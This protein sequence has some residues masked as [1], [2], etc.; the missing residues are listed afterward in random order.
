MGKRQ[1]RPKYRPYSVGKFRLNWYVDQF[2]ASWDDNGKRR[3]CR[4][5]VRTEDAARTALHLFAEQQQRLIAPE[6]ETIRRLAVAYIEDRREEGK[7]ADRMEGCWKVLA[8]TF[9]ALR[10]RDVT[11]DICRGYIA[12]RRAANRADGTI[13]RELSVLRTMFTWAARNAMIDAAPFVWMPPRPAPRDRHLTRDEVAKL[14]D[15][16]EMPHLRLFVVLAIVTA[17]RMQAILGLTW[18]R[19]DFKRGLIDLHDPEQRK[20]AKGRAIVPMNETARAALLEAQAGA[21]SPFVIEWAGKRV[22]SIKKGMRSALMRAGVR[23]KGD[24]AH[25]LRHTAAV[26][27]AEDGVSMS[28]IAQYLGH[29]NT[30][31]TEK[32]YARFSPDY[33]RKAAGSLNLPA[34]RK[35]VR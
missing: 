27:M 29:S 23:M 24:G 21:L 13:L 9:G 33:L 20:S 12:A 1:R 6:G 15:C 2:A 28:E 30:T 14:L 11:R 18:M 5:G 34:A 26:W 10:P 4:L 3:R 17:A 7:W 31:V 16:A 19:V 35:V 32:V 25:L 8:P 22:G